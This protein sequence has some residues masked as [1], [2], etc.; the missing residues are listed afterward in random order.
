MK[1][2]LYSAPGFRRGLA[3]ALAGIFL[4]MA[5]AISWSVSHSHSTTSFLQFEPVVDSVSQTC[6]TC[7]E[8]NSANN[9]NQSK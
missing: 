3:I 8:K 6:S 9:V 2:K 4:W 5:W 7:V 1:F